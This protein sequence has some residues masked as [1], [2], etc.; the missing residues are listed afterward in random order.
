MGIIKKDEP[1]RLRN[2]RDMTKTRL[3]GIAENIQI[4]YQNFL[5]VRILC[6]RAKMC[7][8]QIRTDTHIQIANLHGYIQ[9]DPSKHCASRSTSKNSYYDSHTTK[10]YIYAYYSCSHY[11]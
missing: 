9:G 1:N 2:D 10:K 8:P 11:C 6:M 7:N 4:S 5:H 3:E